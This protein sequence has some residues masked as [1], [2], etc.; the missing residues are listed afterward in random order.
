MPAIEIRQL[1]NEEQFEVSY[2][3]GGYAF[4]STP[5]LPDPDE[6]HQ[7]ME[8]LSDSLYLALFA[9]NKPVAVAGCSPMTQ[10]VR[11]QVFPAGGIWG[12]A[13]HPSARRRG[14][15]RQL[16]TS[17]F[18]QMHTIGMPFSILYPFRQSFY[19]HMGYVNFPHPRI[20]EFPVS[21]LA[22]LLNIPLDGDV[23]LLPISE[24]F[25]LY[26]SFL[27]KRQST[28][29]G[30]ALFNDL[31]SKM[32]QDK[33]DV[34]LAIARSHGDPVGMMLYYIK[35]KDDNLTIHHFY[36]E[37]GLGKFLLLEWLARHIDQ[38]QDVE[39]KLHPSEHPEN[40]LNDLGILI[41]VSDA[42]M[43]RIIDVSK[44]SGLQVGSGLLHIHVNDPL[45][46]WNQG[47]FL[48]ESVDG[49]LQV[50]PSS[51]ADLNLSIQALS[52]LVYG[53]AEPSDFP[54]RGWGSLSQSQAQICLS[55]F[56]HKIPY[57]HEVF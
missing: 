49:Q 54:F 42:P 19:D 14:Y 38:V 24:G 34:W 39:M 53:I 47:N 20:F 33:G 25:P 26:R 57:L 30:M 48:F 9:D 2:Q 35:G 41:N 51:H 28:T 15:S 1:Q 11:G 31:T 12:V 45:C 43:V 7:T 22:P 17:L 36:Y 6:W 27:L 40:W 13:T 4:R 16:L 18:S 32:Q 44:I 37:N 5:P 46:P 3:I 21:S 52:S 56:P 29:H 50:S 8:Y 23:E 10:Q 55:L